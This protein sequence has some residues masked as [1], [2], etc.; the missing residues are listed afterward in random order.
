M[1]GKAGGLWSNELREKI[2]GLGNLE[3]RIYR[4]G[5]WREA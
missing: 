1:W 2:Q 3:A 5:E 4:C